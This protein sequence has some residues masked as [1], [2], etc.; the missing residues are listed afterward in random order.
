M[1]ASFF[2]LNY[3]RFNEADYGAY[4]DFFEQA[5]ASFADIEVKELLDL[6]CGTGELAFRFDERGYDVTAIDI[7]CDMLSVAREKAVQTGRDNILFLEQDMRSFEL[8]GTVDA[9]V[10]A[11]DCFNYLSSLKDL[12]SCFALLNNYI[13][14]GGL[15]VFDMNSPYRY[16]EVYADNCYVFEDGEDMLV[17]QNSY[18]QKRGT[19][20]FFLSFFEESGGFYK[21][22]DE[23][24]RQKCFNPS[25]V[26]NLLKKCGFELCGV[27]GSTSGEAFCETSEK[28]YV[29][30][31]NT[32]GKAQG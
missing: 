29:V 8:Y 4:L 28:F 27:Y 3:D 17:W 10:C 11:Y 18:N 6:G 31:K 9:A 16:K 19:C 25:G 32:G 20:D 23:L 13:R 5:K 30:A 7:S 24:H 26:Q 1:S 15:L 14:R 21:R 2:A 12:E 22:S